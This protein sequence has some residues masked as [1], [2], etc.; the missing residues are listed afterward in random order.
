MAYATGDIILDDEYNVFV[1]GLAGGGSTDSA[2]LNNVWG[3]GQ[4][5]RG[6]GQ[7]TTLSSVTA[8]TTVTATQWATLLARITSS[9]NHQSS[10]ISAMTTPSSTDII[11]IIGTIAGNLTTIHT[12]R[13]NAGSV[14]TPVSANI[15]STGSWTTS[16]TQ[17]ITFTFTDPDEARYFFN[18]GG[19]I[20]IDPS[21][22][23]YTD[24]AKA[25]SWDALTQMCGTVS[26]GAQGSSVS[27]ETNSI[28]VTEAHTASSASVSTTIG[29]YDL[30]TSNQ[31]IY[32]K[33][34]TTAGSPY[35]AGA[36]NNVK[37][38]AKSNGTQGSYSDAGT[39]IT[40]EVQFNDAS[41]DDSYDK[42]DYNVLDEM[43]GTVRNVSIYTPPSTSYL[44]QSWSNPTVALNSSTHT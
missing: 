20:S 19:T 5:D 10:S 15:D 4:A 12:N 23:G 34:L 38:Y 32:E 6:Y 39:I 11:T 18:C 30:T 22:T 36:A 17:L 24:D 27:G 41:T 16:A 40:L 21:V 25:R 42:V 7:S 8:G 3:T 14:G 1:T 43:D 2:N 35:I 33:S 13:L 37:I 29:Y 28:T 31:L 9:A 26:L 44:T